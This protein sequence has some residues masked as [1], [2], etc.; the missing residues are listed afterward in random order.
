MEPYIYR[1]QCLRVIDGDTVDLY[2]DQGFH[3]YRIERFRL[4]GVDT[5]ELTSKDALERVKA[6]AAKEFVTSKLSPVAAPTGEWPLLVKTSKAD[7][8]GRWLC[9]LWVGDLWI[10]KALLDEGLAVPFKK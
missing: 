5:P 3:S 6:Q 9:E 4:L 2:L 8:F 1:A 7:S 10:N